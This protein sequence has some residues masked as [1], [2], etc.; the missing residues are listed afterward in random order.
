MV[1]RNVINNGYQL[2]VLKREELK[3]ELKDEL[4]GELKDELKVRE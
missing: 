1:P 4:K 2:I 3:D